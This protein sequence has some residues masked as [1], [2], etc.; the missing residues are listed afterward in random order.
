MYPVSG[1]LLNFHLFES[2][3]ENMKLGF[4][5]KICEIKE[6]ACF[7]SMLKLKSFHFSQNIFSN[8]K[9]SSLPLSRHVAKILYA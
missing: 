3:T 6:S 7:E 9:L 4:C 5:L 8:R 2:F 1:F